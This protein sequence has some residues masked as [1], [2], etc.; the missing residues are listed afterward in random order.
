MK[1]LNIVLSTIAL[2]L[3]LSFLG[4]YIGINQKLAQSNLPKLYFEGDISEMQEKTDIRSITVKYQSNNY[5]FSGYADLKV[6]DT[7]SL[8]YDKKNY[9]ITFFQDKNHTEKLK[10]DVGWG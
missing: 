6:Q 7:S 2:L 1:K 9:T 10:V 8:A 3:A 4:G 5:S